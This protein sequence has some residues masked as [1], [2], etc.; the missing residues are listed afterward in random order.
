MPRF[1]KIDSRKSTAALAESPVLCYV[2]LWMPAVSGPSAH[3]QM[4][5]SEARRFGKRT[6]RP[7][8][9]QSHSYL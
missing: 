8:E 4:I 5:K 7:S 9:S 3:F 1:V 2:G 6:L